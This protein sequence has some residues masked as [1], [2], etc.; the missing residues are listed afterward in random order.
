MAYM[1]TRFF[2]VCIILICS[3]DEIPFQK[4]I[5]G[6]IHETR[7]SLLRKFQP[8]VES[9]PLWHMPKFQTGV[10]FVIYTSH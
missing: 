5:D 9:P 2:T 4:K 1:K 3:S 7:A 8:E 6:K 10:S